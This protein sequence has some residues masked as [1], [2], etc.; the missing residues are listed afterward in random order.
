MP[1]PCCP[2]EC[3][4]ESC[5]SQICCQTKGCCNTGCRPACLTSQILRSCVVAI[6]SI[7]LITSLFPVSYY[8]AHAF[9]PKISGQSPQKDLQDLQMSKKSIAFIMVLVINL[10]FN[11]TFLVGAVN[12][13]RRQRWLIQWMIVSIISIIFN[14]LV[15]EWCVYTGILGYA[16]QFAVN[17]KT[18][19]ESGAGGDQ[20]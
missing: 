4:L 7:Y 16:D 17:E 3:D 13:L 10:I 15:L 8:L 14:G 1:K 11:F 2:S 20:K 19:G 12:T 5:E 6:G 9:L 18:K